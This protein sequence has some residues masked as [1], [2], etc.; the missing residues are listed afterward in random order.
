M[1]FLINPYRFTSSW[2][3]SD[4]GADLYTWN[5]HTNL[6]TSGS[7][8]SWV[9]DGSGIATITPVGGVSV[10]TESNGLRYVSLDGV[11]DYLSMTGNPLGTPANTVDIRGVCV[12]GLMWIDYQPS[13]GGGVYFG[14]FFGSPN[15]LNFDGNAGTL[16]LVSCGAR[17]VSSA[18][19]TNVQFR[20]VQVT[21]TPFGSTF[22]SA[23]E[24][25]PT[26]QWV[27]YAMLIPESGNAELI[28]NSSTNVVATQAI[29]NSARVPI[30]YIGARWGSTSGSADAFFKGRKSEFFGF[31]A[32]AADASTLSKVFTY[33]NALKP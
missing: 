10:A 27:S 12:S 26:R 14:S 15:T 33:L 28:I 23:T 5:P 18:T 31:N 19:P 17:H 24:V 25:I 2:S 3:P 8:S 22:E 21:S 4:L 16:D 1:S 32:A 13:I 30:K 7:L 6:P 9:D 29:V 11:A 20:H